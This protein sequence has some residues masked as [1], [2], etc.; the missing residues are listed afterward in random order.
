MISC[1]E[2]HL[3]CH[4]V[5]LD[6]ILEELNNLNI[7]SQILSY[8]PFGSQN[9]LRINQCPIQAYYWVK[10]QTISKDL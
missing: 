2:L 9:I 10:N 7:I 6:D 5:I 4:S 1:Q 3:I 8:T